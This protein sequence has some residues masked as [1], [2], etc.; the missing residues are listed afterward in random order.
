MHEVDKLISI[1]TGGARI[2]VD[3]PVDKIGQL[4]EEERDLANALIKIAAKYGKFNED[5]TGIWAG[6]DRASMNEVKDIGVK[7]SNCVLYQGGASCAII[8]SAVEPEGK[9]RFAIIPDGVVKMG[10]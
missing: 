7:C 5:G 4:V 6:Y 2:I 8:A 10:K 9:C 1:L 3:K